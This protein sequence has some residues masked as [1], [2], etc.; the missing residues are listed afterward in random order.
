MEIHLLIAGPAGMGRKASEEQR[1]LCA[2]LLKEAQTAESGPPKY[3][4]YPELRD[5]S[6]PD[7]VARKWIKQLTSRGGSGSFTDQRRRGRTHKVS[8]TAAA[9]AARIVQAGK[10][11][12]GRRTAFLSWGDAFRCSAKLRRI[13]ADCD[14]NEKTLI[15][16]MRLAKPKPKLGLIKSNP[17][18]LLQR[19]G[20]KASSGRRSGGQS[21]RFLITRITE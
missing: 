17:A 6:R 10:Q 8:K 1:A 12:V 19:R 21:A 15:R 3:S 9:R 18:L 2:F 4:E 13:Q 7:R 20:G 5:V 11:C 16:A 14:C